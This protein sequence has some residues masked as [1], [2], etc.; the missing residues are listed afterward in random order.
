MRVSIPRSTRARQRD[1]RRR[2]L[3]KCNADGEDGGALVRGGARLGLPSHGL[4]TSDST[5][6]CVR[7]PAR[8]L[9][10][11]GRLLPEKDRTGTGDGKAAEIGTRRTQ[12]RLWR[13]RLHPHLPRGRGGDEGWAPSI[14][15]SARARRARPWAR[16]YVDLDGIGISP[17]LVDD[18]R[19]LIHASWQLHP[20][21][22]RIFLVTR[23]DSD[24]ISPSRFVRRE[25]GSKALQWR[26]ADEVWRGSWWMQAGR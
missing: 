24:A 10:A 22:T 11:L 1:Q 3:A 23:F 2:Y 6:V 20:H 15:A 26:S 16:Q 13:S 9:N 25:D 17:G 14:S 18:G 21:R 4:D 19:R 7:R 5:R 8:G 12:R